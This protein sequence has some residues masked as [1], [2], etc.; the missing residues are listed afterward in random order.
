MNQTFYIYVIF[1]PNLISYVFFVIQKIRTIIKRIL[2]DFP[3]IIFLQNTL[4]MNTEIK[5]GLREKLR[6]G[7]VAIENF[8]RAFCDTLYIQSGRSHYKL[9]FQTTLK[10]CKKMQCILY[11]RVCTCTCM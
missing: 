10:Y 4:L 8:L 1:E 7:F 5:P 9:L 2:C 11:L 3:A 6:M